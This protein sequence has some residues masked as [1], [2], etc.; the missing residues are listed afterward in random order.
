MIQNM[1]GGM[2]P[3]DM[4]KMMQEMMPKCMN[5]MFAQI[6]PEKRAAFAVEMLS[7]IC[8]QLKKYAACEPEKDTSESTNNTGDKQDD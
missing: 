8:D 1:V 2:N 7:R 6:E 4:P 5:M 3:Q